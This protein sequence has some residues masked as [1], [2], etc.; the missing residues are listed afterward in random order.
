MK[1]LITGYQGFIGSNVASYLKAKGHDVEGFPWNYTG[2]QMF[3]G[4]IELYT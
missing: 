2:T 4:M 1:I 3:N